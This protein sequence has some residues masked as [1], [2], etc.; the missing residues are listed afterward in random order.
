MVKALGCI[1]DA[2]QCR[3]SDDILMDKITKF[4][5]CIESGIDKLYARNGT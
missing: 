5:E 2:A 3:V 4:N 1:I